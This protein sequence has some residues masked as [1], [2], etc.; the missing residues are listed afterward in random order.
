M[1][2]QRTSV[3]RRGARMRSPEHQQWSAGGR[4]QLYRHFQTIKD[5]RRRAG[6]GS[7]LDPEIAVLLAI[8][9]AILSFAADYFAQGHMLFALDVLVV[10]VLAAVIASGQAGLN[11]YW[12]QTAAGTARPRIHWAEWLTLCIGGLMAVNYVVGDLKF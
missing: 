2:G 4:Y 1:V 6:A 3:R 10:A 5:L 9:S 7:V 8:V 12:Q 11:A